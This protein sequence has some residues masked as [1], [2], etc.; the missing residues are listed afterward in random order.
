MTRAL[1]RHEAKEARVIPI[2][3]KPVDWQG[4]PFGKLQALP[5]NGKPVTGWPDVEDAFL[6]I[7][8]GIRLV[9]EEFT[10][11]NE[12]A[13]NHRKHIKV[14]PKLYTVRWC[15]VLSATIDDIDRPRAEAIAEHLRELSGDAKLTIKSI[16][17]GSVKI[18][19]EGNIKGFLKIKS[20][21]EKKELKSI[22]VYELLDVKVQAAGGKKAARQS[23]AMAARPYYEQALAINRKVLGEEHPDTAQSLNNLGALLRATGDYAAARPYYEQALAIRKKVLGEEHPDTASSLNNLGALLRATGDY[24]GARPYYEQA[25]AIRKKVLGEEHPD[26]AQSL[27]NLGD[28]L[29]VHRRL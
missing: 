29:R 5:K 1:E 26:T 7:A 22:L 9:T 2:I 18:Y 21:F 23:K 28:L 13:V 25:L 17:P 6:N 15:I 3:L 8:K 20:L 19:F 24:D 16:E 14:V 12:E 4:A 11:Q 27:N 10:G